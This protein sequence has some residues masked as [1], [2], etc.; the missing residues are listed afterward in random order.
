MLL[1]SLESDMDNLRT[2]MESIDE[3]ASFAG[4]LDES[5]KRKEQ[6]KERQK[7]RAT[8]AAAE[9]GADEASSKAR[10][11]GHLAHR[12]KSGQTHVR[13]ARAAAEHSA[14]A[15][16]FARA[17]APG[18]KAKK[19]KE[20][21]GP[22]HAL[23]RKQRKQA[24]T[25]NKP[26]AKKA[27]HQKKKGAH[28]F[29]NETT[30][31]KERGGSHDPGGA[32]VSTPG[33]RKKLSKDPKR[34]LKFPAG[35]KRGRYPIR[36]GNRAS[37]AGTLRQASKRDPFIYR[38][39]VERVKSA[40]SNMMH[41]KNDPSTKHSNVERPVPLGGPHPIRPHG[42]G[43]LPPDPGPRLKA[44]KKE[45]KGRAE[46]HEGARKHARKRA[47]KDKFREAVTGRS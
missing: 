37:I 31:K 13:A 23:S 12:T 21:G 14:Q 36:G 46:K 7:G 9:R 40:S 41:R 27:K 30:F 15:A 17:A 1:S 3:I 38:K 42:S 22:E 29:S 16:A 33:L 18:K 8:A 10:E 39:A 20:G 26:A 24:R 11:A 6:R 2:L 28:K 35:S 5:R 32:M 4:I 43:G 19:S 34:F 25:Y 47:N 45:T 44:D